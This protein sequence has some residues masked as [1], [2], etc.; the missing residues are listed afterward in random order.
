MKASGRVVGYEDY[1]GN[2]NPDHMD[3]RRHLES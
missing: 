3:L 2:P 1:R